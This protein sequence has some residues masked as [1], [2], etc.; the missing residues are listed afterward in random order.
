MG[1]TAILPTVLSNDSANTSLM[2]ITYVLNRWLKMLTN[3][4]KLDECSLCSDI[5]IISRVIDSTQV[6]DNMWRAMVNCRYYAITK[7]GSV[8]YFMAQIEKTLKLLCRKQ[9]CHEIRK[10]KRNRADQGMTERYRPLTKRL[11][12]EKIRKLNKHM[13]YVDLDFDN[14]NDVKLIRRI[15]EKRAAQDVH[16]WNNSKNKETNEFRQRVRRATSFSLYQTS[17]TDYDARKRAPGT[18][19][20]IIRLSRK[21]KV[22]L[23]SKKG[24]SSYEAALE[25]CNRYVLSHPEDRIPM[26]AYK[27][28]FC[29]KWHIGHDR[30]TKTQDCTKDCIIEDS[31][32]LA[33]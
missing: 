19:W 21:G 33:S 17:F 20:R 10:I 6:V 24:Y 23:K 18:H 25:A 22:I 15:V 14:S 26:S 27:C 8:E 32:A 12:K 3:Y 1:Q 9:D 2:E 11:E 5:E 30:E 28:E 31:V 4:G 16:Q 13:A 7:S 29:G